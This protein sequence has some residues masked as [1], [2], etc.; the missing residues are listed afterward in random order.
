[1]F[2][3]ILK[4]CIDHFKGERT[5]SGIYNLLT[6]KRSSQTMQDAKG[7]NLDHYFGVFPSLKR[8]ELDRHIEEILDLREISLENGVFPVLTAKGKKKLH[9]YDGPLLDSFQGM[10]LHAIIP[11]FERRLN[12]LTQTATNLQA[13]I[14]SFVPIIDDPEVQKWVKAVY[15]NVQQKVPQLVQSLHQEISQLLAE[16]SSIEAELF[17]Y[18]LSGGGIIGLTIEQL[19][20]RF[21]L[22][23][24]DVYICLFHMY[25]I[26]FW[27]GKRGQE[28]YPVLHLCTKGLDSSHMITH[29]AQKTYQ[30]LNQGLS[31]EEVTTL[32]RLKRSTIQDHIVEAALVI[33]HFSI[34]PFIHPDDVDEILQKARHLDTQR[35]KHIHE[36]FDGKYDYFELRLAMAGRQTQRKEGYAYDNS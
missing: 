10:E 20:N 16:R 14:T 36:A 29:S 13:D 15:A 8:N 19:Q 17:A 21:Q 35:L 33:P 5:L 11:V 26:L 1:M 34:E 30:Y 9:D 31:I 2:D 6:G 24:E 23:R 32:R 28:K 27:R 18:R 12:L 4:V 22:T 25:H 7:Y 3:F